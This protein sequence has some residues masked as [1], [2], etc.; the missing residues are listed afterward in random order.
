MILNTKKR[1]CGIL[2]INYT[3]ESSEGQ[4]GIFL[5]ICRKI[6]YPENKKNYKEARRPGKNI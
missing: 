6:P 1:V 2:L 4:W 5:R 3:F